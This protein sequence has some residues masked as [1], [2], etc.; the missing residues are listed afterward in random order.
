[1][2]KI[3]SI[4]ALLCFQMLA[5]SGAVWA[6]QAGKIQ[7]TFANRTDKTVTFFLNG[8]QGLETRLRAGQSSGYTMVVDQ[9]VQP[10]V[11]IYQPAGGGNPR[12][13]NVANGGRYAFRPKNNGVENH[14]DE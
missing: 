1:M 5:A 2:R 6:Q 12:K 11:T 10:T 7:V 9:G 13:F 14:F 4:S 8:G 3:F